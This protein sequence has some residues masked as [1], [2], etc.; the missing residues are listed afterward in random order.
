MGL[1][2][3]APRRRGRSS[4]RQALFGSVVGWEAGVSFR[5]GSVCLPGRRDGRQTS[6]GEDV[7]AC[8]RPLRGRRR[9]TPGRS[10]ARSANGEFAVSYGCPLGRSTWIHR[11]W[12]LVFVALCRAWGRWVPATRQTHVVARVETS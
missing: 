8:A 12:F 1:P 10:P 6:L 5:G 11:W 7:W 3:A 9:A 4:R 2:L